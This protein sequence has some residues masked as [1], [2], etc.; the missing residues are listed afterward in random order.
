MNFQLKPP[1]IS[2]IRAKRV[3]EKLTTVHHSGD[4]TLFATGRT[5]SGKTTLGN[6]LLGI[7]YFL[8]TGRQDCTTNINL[9]EFPIGLK[10]FDL[11]GVCSDDKLE[12]LNRVS[13]GLGQVDEFP[14]VED[15][16]L[17]KFKEGEP[18]NENRFT[19]SDFDKALFKPDLVFYL[20]APDK[21][22]GRCDRKYLIDLLKKHSK[23]IYV[24]NLFVNKQNQ[25]IYMATEPNLLDIVTKI[26]KIHTS[27]LGCDNKPVIV[28]VNCW[29]GEGISELVIRTHDVIGGVKGTLLEELI[30]FQQEHTPNEYLSQVTNELLRLCAY[31]A[32]Q[33]PDGTCSCDQAIHNATHELLQFIA[34]LKRQ[35]TQKDYCIGEM[36]TV[37]AERTFEHLLENS[38]NENVDT[39]PEDEEYVSHGLAIINATIE[40]I[41]A[42]VIPPFLDA[43]IK[44]DQFKQNEIKLFKKRINYLISQRDSF[45][46]EIENCIDK[47]KTL[48]EKI[49][50]SDIKIDRLREKQNLRIQSY[51]SLQETITIRVN[52]CRYREER[53]NSRLNNYNDAIDRINSG[54]VRPTQSTLDSLESDGNYLKREAA[55]IDDERTYLNKL[56][57]SLKPKEKKIDDK[58][59]LDKNLIEQH[60][61]N[62]ST[63][64]KLQKVTKNK[65]NRSVKHEKIAEDESDFYESAIHAFETDFYAINEL[66]ESRINIINER[67]E[68][69][70]QCF[71]GDAESS[72]VQSNVSVAEIMELINEMNSFIDEIHLFHERLEKCTIKLTFDKLAGEVCK[73][74]TTHYFDDT[75]EFAYKGSTHNHFHKD[76]IAFLLATTH[77]IATNNNIEDNFK[78]IY[79]AILAKLKPINIHANHNEHK[80]FHS[81]EST[82]SSLFNDEF[83]CFVRSLAC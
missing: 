23:V 74:A 68:T 45:I 32:R 21:Q 34:N 20:I 14:I 29:T 1:S 41:N 56:I 65:L 47:R 17:A 49:R 51:N 76:G 4:I 15:L 8:S 11:P 2:H 62:V 48:A 69:I 73:R 71:T 24:L 42:Q 61:L 55:S 31:I 50:S 19:I 80:I 6:R 10:Y 53:W 59:K 78:G 64:S 9:V 18:P 57:E 5:G 70:K 67:L 46:V 22:F 13:L 81:L 37:M 44:A 63:Y 26:T 35:T 75:E 52:K 3:I 16:L 36:V 38:N 77:S 28:G 58:E 72:Q 83:C 12:N 66:K 79:D 7:D 33:K 43:Q 25:D 82:K 60:N 30:N 40:H 39:N 54:R 27:V